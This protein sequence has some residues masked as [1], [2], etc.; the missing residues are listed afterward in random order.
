MNVQ[1]NVQGEECTFS[2]WGRSKMY[3]LGTIA[4]SQT[5]RVPA[6]INKNGAVAKVYKSFSEPRDT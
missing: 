6:E 4:I 2:S 1:L 5:Q 3:T